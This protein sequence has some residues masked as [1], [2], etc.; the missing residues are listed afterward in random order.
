MWR[1]PAHSGEVLQRLWSPETQLAEV[2]GPD[3]VWGAPLHPQLAVLLE[4]G[5]G[6]GSGCRQPGSREG[7]AGTRSPRQV[8]A[9]GHLPTPLPGLSSTPR[10][11]G[12]LLPPVPTP[13][14]SLKSG[15]FPGPG[16][17]PRPP[18]KVR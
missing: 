7:Q 13:R 1:E 18:E 12:I 15:P 10:R 9:G 14:I 6:G 8:W 3:E 2:R 16:L 17:E 4:A 11:A 5:W